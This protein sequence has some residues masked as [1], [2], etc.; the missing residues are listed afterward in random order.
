MDVIY[1]DKNGT[2]QGVL[3]NFSIDLDTAN[4]MNFEITVGMDNHVMTGGSLWYIE[5]TEYGG[6]IDSIEVV[7][8]EDAVK[9]HGRS[10]RG[11][12]A[13]K[14][15]SPPPGEDYK[16]VSG[17]MHDIINGMLA[18]AGIAED[19]VAA[20]SNCTLASFQFARYITLYEGLLKLANACK[21]VLAITVQRDK[22]TN[23][24]K[25]VISFSERINY[26]DEKEYNQDDLMFRITK[27]YIGINHLICIG[28]GELKE[29]QVCHLYVDA[30]GDIVERQY[31]FGMS[32][33]AEVYEN[34]SCETLESLKQAGID[35][36]E[37]VKSGD[38]FEVS[39]PELEL[40]IGDMI[41]GYE[42]VTGYRVVREI[43]NTIVTIDDVKVNIEYIVGG[44]TPEWVSVPGQIVTEYLLPVATES[45]L[46]G[47]KVGATMEIENG[48]LKAAAVNNAMLALQEA[49]EICR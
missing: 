45:V 30:D 43:V 28:Q 42:K 17:N 15:I 26:A 7:T 36:L 16:I 24:A 2:E 31:F 46:G 13:K 21:K 32:E 48:M 35:H 1:T 29:R 19:F 33:V 44:E 9:Y 37:D 41:G 5:G 8:E 39:A 20:K 14:V 49:K 23:K 12:L 40:K 22:E 25:K 34:T 38:S 6:M 4:Q 47:V 18:D 11:M 27:S 10:F 3:Q